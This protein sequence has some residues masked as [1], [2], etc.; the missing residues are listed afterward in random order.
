MLPISP[1][2]EKSSAARST[3]SCGTDNTVRRYKQQCP[4]FLCHVLARV[5]IMFIYFFI[6]F[7]TFFIV[8]SLKLKKSTAFGSLSIIFQ[9]PV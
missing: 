2:V 9:W 4:P 3:A 5:V 1:L 6:T 8:V 7:I